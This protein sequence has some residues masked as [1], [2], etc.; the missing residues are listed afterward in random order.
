MLKLEND[1]SLALAQ[2]DYVHVVLCFQVA[3]IILIGRPTIKQICYCDEIAIEIL[4]RVTKSAIVVNKTASTAG[5][6]VITK[7]QFANFQW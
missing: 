1:F 4:S 5:A 3:T 6:A 2:A 7:T